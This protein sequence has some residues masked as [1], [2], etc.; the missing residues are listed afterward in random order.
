MELDQFDDTPLFSKPTQPAH[1]QATDR[2][3]GT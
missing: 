1:T 2:S 3:D